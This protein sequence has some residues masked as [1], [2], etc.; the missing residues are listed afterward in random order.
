[1]FKCGRNDGKT[2][3]R[4]DG[5]MDR[6]K[7]VYPPK[8][9]FCGGYNNVDKVLQFSHRQVVETVQTLIRLLLE[10]QCLYSIL[11]QLHYLG[12]HT[13]VEPLCLNFRVFTIQ[14][15]GLQ[16]FSNFMVVLKDT[17]CGCCYGC[18]YGTHNAYQ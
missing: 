17:A 4:K 14:L 13:M 18:S 5:R 9:P 1:M 7:T 6:L 12:Y 3:G 15:V 11:F 8:T 2:E 16:H 10:G